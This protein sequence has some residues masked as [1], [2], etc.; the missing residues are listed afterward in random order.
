M[1]VKATEANTWPA[2]CHWSVGKE[3]EITLAKGDELP[4]WLVEV[5]ATKKVKAKD[6]EKADAVG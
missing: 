2:G 3:R 5:K 4:G 6:V 1:K